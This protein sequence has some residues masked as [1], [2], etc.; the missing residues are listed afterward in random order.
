MF[1]DH[2]YHRFGSGPRALVV[3]LCLRTQEE[4]ESLFVFPE[5]SDDEEDFE[6]L[7]REQL[8]E[9]VPEDV[10]KTYIAFEENHPC[11]NHRLKAW[12]RYPE[13]MPI[14]C[15]EKRVALMDEYYWD[16]ISLYN[17]RWF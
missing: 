4:K 1:Q 11:R 3:K 13:D 16:Y 2:Y 17:V 8:M 10:F 7:S 14:V 5:Y 9:H 15:S 12:N 6:R